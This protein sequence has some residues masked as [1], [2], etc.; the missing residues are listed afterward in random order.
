[1]TDVCESHNPCHRDARCTTIAPGQTKCTCRKGYIGDGSRCYGNIM[2]RLRE[3]NTE[4]GGKWQGRLTSFI[5]LLDK[6][7]AWPLS[8]LGPFTL[9]L[10]TDKGLKGFNVKELL[11][12]NEA[13]RYFVKLHIIAGQMNTEQMTTLQMKT[14]YTLTGKSGEIFNGDKDNQV[15][16]KLCG[17]KKKVNIIQGNIIAS[18]GLLHIL[19]RAM[20]KVA[21][22]F[23][24]NNEQTIMTML[25]PRYSKF[26]SLLEETN[27]GH[28]LDEDGVGGPYTIF[29][30]SNEALNNMKDGALDYLLSSEGSRKLLELVRYHIV[31]FTQLE[32]ATLISTPHIRSMANQV[33]RFNTTD[34]GQILANGVAMEETEVAAKNGRIYTLTG[35]LI[36][37]SITPVLPHRCDETKREMKL[38]TCVSCSLVYWSKCPADS[39]P[40]TLFKQMCLQW[41]NQEPEEWCARY[42]MP[43]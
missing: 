25:Q 23:E 3:L 20:D 16:L 28:A 35:V 33:I 7:Y 14:F 8:N 13:A 27:M 36:P 15:K 31:P 34:N 40:M 18:N 37:P 2:E 4:P 38:G 10:P 11:K 42:C 24:S 26:R 22:T 6:A 19:D 12:D 1:M 39:E 17:G 32:V 30:P 43:L 5:S 41:P 9:L 21:P 29:V